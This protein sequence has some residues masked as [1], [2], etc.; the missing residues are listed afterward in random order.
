MKTI[1][2]ITLT[3]L[4]FIETPLVWGKDAPPQVK[5]EEAYKL[6]GNFADKN[7][8]MIKKNRNPDLIYKNIERSS[9]LRALIGEECSTLTGNL[10][11]Q[12][13]NLNYGTAT[14][15]LSL[16][17][18]QSAEYYVKKKNKKGAKKVYRE[19]VTTFIEYPAYKSDVKKAEFALE[20]LK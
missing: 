2:F 6:I 17:M 13:C 15:M 1:F 11:I 10:E 9:V 4:L 5:H 19:I 18:F 12:I 3:V 7:N 20:D 14:Q 8:E 16:M